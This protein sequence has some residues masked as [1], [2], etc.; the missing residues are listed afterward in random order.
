MPNLSS[1]L[2]VEI[3]E[4]VFASTFGL[5]RI[6][7]GATWPIFMATSDSTC[8]SGSLSTLNCRIPPPNAIS[9]SA[10]VFPTPE[11]TI[12]SP[13]TPALRALAYSPP[14]TT[15]MPAPASARSV[16]IAW[17]EAAFIA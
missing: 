14:D 7:T 16:N 6:V 8:I 3:L 10:R 2:P 5:I 17:L 9:I 11:K 13:G 15:S 12:S 1:F 4:C